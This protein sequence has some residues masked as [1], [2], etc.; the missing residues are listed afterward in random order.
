MNS[1]WQDN[2]AQM[3]RNEFEIYGDSVAKNLVSTSV[4][5]A[6]R[7]EKVMHHV[8]A[9]SRSVSLLFVVVRPGFYRDPAKTIV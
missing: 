2:F 7:L 1:T 6:H 8:S 3:I 5:R 9:K 4:A